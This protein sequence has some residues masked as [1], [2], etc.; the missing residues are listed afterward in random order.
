VTLCRSAS[1]IDESVARAVAN[2]P[3]AETGFTDKTHS[4]TPSQAKSEGI[5][6]VM[7]IVIYDNI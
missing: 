6:K 7:I 5:W 1:G 2:A 3:A 4:K